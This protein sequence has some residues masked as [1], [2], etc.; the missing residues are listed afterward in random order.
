MADF[1]YPYKAALVDFSLHVYFST[2]KDLGDEFVHQTWQ[3]I[4]IFSEDI[5]KFLE[6][7]TR[8][9][10]GKAKNLDDRRGMGGKK[11]L[12]QDEMDRLTTVDI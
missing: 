9:N 5:N 12:P 1:C 10:K 7:M 8:A 3:I 6:T 11:T 2:E 4:E